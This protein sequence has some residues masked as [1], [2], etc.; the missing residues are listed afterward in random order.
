MLKLMV[1]DKDNLPLNNDHVS[2]L[3]HI[4]DLHR[5]VDLPWAAITRRTMRRL[6]DGLRDRHPLS[7]GNLSV[8]FQAGH[9]VP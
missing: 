4:G 3:R 2:I 6:A 5:P 8:A 1:I 9:A 7:F